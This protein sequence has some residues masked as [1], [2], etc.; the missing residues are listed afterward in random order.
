MLPCF[1]TYYILLLGSY[2]LTSCTWQNYTIL[3]CVCFSCLYF[4]KVWLIYSIVPSSPIQQNDLAYMYI[5]PFSYTFKALL[6]TPDFIFIFIF[7]FF[8]AFRAT[9]MAYG[10]SQARGGIGATS[11]WP[12][13]QPQQHRIQAESPTYTTAHGN[14]ES[15][16]HRVRPGIEPAS[17]WMLVRFVNC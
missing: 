10:S 1:L 14:T 6:C 16:T 7:L 17:S 15:L 3:Y 13:P 4:I 5:H 12:T 9:L 2:S 8:L 11:C